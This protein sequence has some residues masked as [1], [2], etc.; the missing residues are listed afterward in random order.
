MSVK[1][2]QP[3]CFFLSDTRAY[4]HIDTAKMYQCE[5]AVGQAWRDFGIKREEFWLTSKLDNVDHTAD[6]VGKAC[7]QQLKELQTDY[8][9]LYL[10]H[11]PLTGKAGPTLDPPIKETWQAMEVYSHT[12]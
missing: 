8:L 1:D 6:R 9:D 10:I 5:G 12:L 4:R 3:Q 11:W 2:P 7:R